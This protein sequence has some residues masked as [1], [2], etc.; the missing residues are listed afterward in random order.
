MDGLTVMEIARDAIMTFLFIAG[1]ILGIST[2]VGVVIAFFQAITQIQE[3][4]LTFVPKIL[5]IFGTLLI[6][7]PTMGSYM[8]DLNNELMERIITGGG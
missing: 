1:P 5:A 8:T 4:T 6:L 2:A 3:M 7:L